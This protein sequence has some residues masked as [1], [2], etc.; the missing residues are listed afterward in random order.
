[1]KLPR[2]WAHVV[3]VQPRLGKYLFGG[4]AD[5]SCRRCATKASISWWHDQ[6]ILK[7]TG[8]IATAFEGSF[9]GDPEIN[10]CRKDGSEFWAAIFINPVRDASGG[11]V[12]HFVSSVDFSKHKQGQAQATNAH[13]RA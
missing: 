1:M 8:Q 2:L 7:A 4:V 9:N 5:T 3:G 6:A 11:V 12:Q 13:R 10:C